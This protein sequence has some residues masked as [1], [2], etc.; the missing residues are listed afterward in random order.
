MKRRLLPVLLSTLVLSPVQA[1]EESGAADD[2][3]AV[4]QPA[5]E[6]EAARL[7]SQNL[8]PQLLYQFLLAEIAGT[9]GQIGLSAEAYLDLARSTRDPRVA[10]RAAEIA[11]F[12]RRYDAALEA[13][14]LWA[15]LEPESA[16]ARQ[17]MTSLL[18]GANRSQELSDH[19]SSQLAATGADVSGLLLQLHRVLA[20]HPDKQAAQGLVNKVTE[21]YLGLAEAH[22]A[23]AQ[24]AHDVRDLALATRE[25]DQALALRP[26][27]EQAALGRAQLTGNTPET[28]EFLGRFVAANPQAQDARLAYARGLVGEKRFDEARREF[29]RLLADNQNNGD[30]LFAVAVLSLQLNDFDEAE[31]QLRR[32]VATNHGEINNARLYLGQIAEERKRSEE[33]L[34]WYGQVTAGGQYLPARM[35]MAQILSHQKKLAEA[36]RV[37]QESAATNPA[38][39]GQLVIA[40]A[41]L[42]RE[43]GRF[44]E[45]YAVLADALAAYPDQPE[46]LY[47]TALMA[48]KVG[49]IELVE[50]HLRRLIVL[51]PDHAH[52]YNALGY[53][54]AD[55][56][57]RLDEAQQLIDQAVQLAP[58][59]PFILDSKGWVLFRR[60]NAGG[61]LDV[62]KKAFTLRADPEIAAHLGEVLWALGRQDEARKTW[63][64]AMKTSPGNEVLVGT[65]RKFVP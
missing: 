36:R 62:L 48:E 50:R 56:N 46:L 47:E 55:R 26:D 8:T 18:A 19:L 60:G 24:A 51:K 40:E 57:E 43:V 9:R 17:M 7:P 13:A 30:V 39:R 32:L 27:W 3:A 12:A 21:P 31:K 63:N 42:L 1:A 37:L 5:S 22:F 49:K 2:R 28:V 53:S 33:A 25:L 14:R 38:E 65:V 44:D 54:L 64:D 11:L 23:R 15:A 35:R 34:D 45:A 59:D 16:Q 41:Q 29:Q 61:A 52:A 20:R 58:E 6:P 4:S 10:R